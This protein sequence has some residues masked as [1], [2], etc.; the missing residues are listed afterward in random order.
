MSSLPTV[1][2]VSPLF[3]HCLLFFFLINLFIYWLCWVCAAALGLFSSC[4]VRSPH[5]G[6][7]FSDSGP[8]VSGLS[9]CGSRVLEHQLS[10]CG[11]WA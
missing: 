7:F 5:C 6:G 1:N 4:G 2:V 3:E 11:S 10:N 8:R 9:S